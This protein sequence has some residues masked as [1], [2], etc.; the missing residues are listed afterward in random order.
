MEELHDRFKTWVRHRRG[1]RLQGD[2]TALFDGSWMLG[3][4]ALE[5][6]LVDRLGDTESVVRALGGEK[7]EPEVFRPRRRGLLGRLPRLAADA[8]LDAAEAR[9]FELR[10]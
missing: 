6:G 7:A 1:D 4:R 3:A 5:C 9:R 2:E 8:L 10:M